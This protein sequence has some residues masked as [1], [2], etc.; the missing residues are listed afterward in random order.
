MADIKIVISG[1]ALLISMGLYDGSDNLGKG[2]G[3]AVAID[4]RE[5]F[6]SLYDVDTPGHTAQLTVGGATATIAGTANPSPRFSQAGVMTLT[7]DHLQ[8]GVLSG[9]NCIPLN[10]KVITAGDSLTNIPHLDQ[11][12]HPG[13]IA[14]D[15]THAKPGNNGKDFTT[16]V[17]G[18]L[19]AWLEFAGGT[20][21]ATHAGN[22]AV[23]FHPS[24]KTAITPKTIEVRQKASTANCLLVSPFDATTGVVIRFDL[25]KPVII[26]FK[27]DMDIDADS[28]SRIPGVGF[29]F[30]R[31]YTV[32]SAGSQPTFPALPYAFRKP[33]TGTGDTPNQHGGEANSDTGVNCGPASIP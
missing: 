8:F 6:D 20:A 28:E 9:D 7:G 22:D 26:G 30:E 19:A 14:L 13:T 5:P 17:N 23:E 18:T 29:D 1:M 15:A 32:L 31:F 16:L 27:N 10:A 12:P 33:S 3:A 21:R 24:G 2:Y 25:S 4:S 11:L